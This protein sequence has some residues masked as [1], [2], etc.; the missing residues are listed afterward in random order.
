MKSII[1]FAV[2]LAIA[3]MMLACS[4]K[5]EETKLANEEKV[6]NHETPAIPDEFVFPGESMQ[7]SS[8]KAVTT[9]KSSKEI[10]IEVSEY[11][12]SFVDTSK[13][14]EPV[15][16]DDTSGYYSEYHTLNP[17][18][19]ES[20]CFDYSFLLGTEKAEITLPVSIDEL[21]ERGFTLYGPTN[22]DTIASP[23]TEAVVTLCTP[24]SQEIIGFAAYNDTDTDKTV[25]ELMLDSVTL[26]PMNNFTA[27]GNITN[28][29]DFGTI[30][31]IFGSPDAVLIS[32]ADG[33]CPVTIAYE[34]NEAGY[35]VGVLMDGV[36]KEIIG[37]L[38][39][40]Q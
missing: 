2:C 31:E 39:R 40:I 9:E 16:T 34:D 14:L 15:I 8:D 23:D 3:S 10:G 1:T 28:E 4:S 33:G 13:Y 6:E 25:G 19:H 27:F 30:T 21:L 12:M 5:Q 36:L 32:S 20:L 7:S 11:I 29:S 18:F 24:E 26:L 37:I 38:F 35:S 22:A 17:Q